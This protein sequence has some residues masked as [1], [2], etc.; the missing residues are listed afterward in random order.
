MTRVPTHACHNYGRIID[1]LAYTLR[2]SLYRRCAYF[3]LP[4]ALVYMRYFVTLKQLS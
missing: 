2:A 1:W 3:A 4:S